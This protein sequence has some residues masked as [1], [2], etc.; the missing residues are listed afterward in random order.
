MI[1]KCDEKVIFDGEINKYTTNNGGYTS[2]LFTC[3]LN[4]TK[5]IKE[6]ELSGYE[7][8]IKNQLHNIYLYTNPIE[9]EE[10]LEKGKVYKN[11][12][13]EHGV[14]LVVI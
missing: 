7:N 13:Y 8:E 9:N 5:D 1:I 3:D 6:S 11:I 14:M 12:K 2:I 10:Q 4:I